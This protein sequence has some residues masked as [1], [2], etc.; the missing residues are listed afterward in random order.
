MQSTLLSAQAFRI[1]YSSHRLVIATWRVAKMLGKSSLEPL[2]VL[3]L[4][5]EGHLVV[6]GEV[7]KKQE[8]LVAAIGAPLGVKGIICD[9]GEQAVASR[10]RDWFSEQTGRAAPQLFL[11]GRRPSEASV[12]TSV[13]QCLLL[14]AEASRLSAAKNEKDLAVLRR[15]FERTLI[16]LEKARRVVRGAGYDTKF[17]TMSVPVGEGTLDPGDHQPELQAPYVTAFPLPVDAAGLVGISLHFGVPEEELANGD[18]S[19]AVHRCVDQQLLG[20]KKVPFTDLAGGWAYFELER[21][22]QRSFGDAELVI[23]WTFYEDGAGPLLSLSDSVLSQRYEDAGL[24][25]DR[26]PAMQLWSGFSPGELE[27]DGKFRPHHL[28]AKRNDFASLYKFFQPFGAST[29]DADS[30][31]LHKSSVQTHLQGG[32]AGL[33]GEALVPG[34]AQAVEV[35]F[36]T[37][38]RS[39]PDCLYL[40]VVGTSGTAVTADDVEA[41]YCKALDEGQLG[42]VDEDKEFVW[43]ATVAPPEQSLRMRLDIPESLRTKTPSSLTLAVRSVSG[44]TSYGWCRWHSLSVYLPPVEALAGQLPADFKPDYSQLRRMRSLKF[45]EVGEQLQFL[46]G[47]QALHKLSESLGFSPMIVGEDNGSLQTHPMLEEVSAALY[48]GGA[49]VGTVRV[50]CDVETAH[51]RSP[52][53]RY[54]LALIPSETEDKYM[55]FKAFLENELPNGSQM[56]NGFAS[57]YGIHYGSRQLK[58]L[59][60]SLISV[61]LD[62]PLESSF[63][64]IVAV[65]PAEGAVS[66]GWC[67]WMS[68]NVSSTIDTHQHFLLTK[69]PE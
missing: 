52:A 39:A 10:W 1:F 20:F 34:S 67:R 31:T 42:G 44:G 12:L 58:A 23:S 45:P 28:E 63:D 64:I 54:I 26:L 13:S 56:C 4:K 6:P 53:F 47:T 25:H 24:A 35:S 49:P 40:A 32:I 65:L 2:D 11:L 66:Y 29:A 30:I 38:H 51:E 60:S 17:T 14:D 16:N 37:A 21:P 48:Q 46:A 61:D 55:A 19:V 62:T 9:A 33:S 5:P 50:S 8:E 15:D 59:Q 57:K 69:Q 22:M 27:D 36:G 3:L 43:Q 18:L 68:L 7:V 41:L